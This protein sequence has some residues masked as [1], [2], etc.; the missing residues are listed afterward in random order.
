[1]KIKFTIFVSIIAVIAGISSCKNAKN[2]AQL[3]TIDSLYLVLDSV[4]KTITSVDTAKVNKVFLEYQGNI[5]KIKQYF[6]DKKDDSTWSTITV[7]GVIRKPIKEFNKNISAFSEDLIFS[8]KQLDSLKSDIKANNIPEEKIKEYTKA[9][10]DA[11]NSL[12]QQVNIVIP[13]TKETLH[14]FDSLN[15]KVIKII[16]KLEK[17]GKKNPNA[18]AEEEAD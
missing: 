16:K 2:H 14:L 10:V 4:E 15:P 11:V 9:E 12:R 5:K 3:S 7:Y 18:A 13:H 6:D 17:T 1:M 8:R